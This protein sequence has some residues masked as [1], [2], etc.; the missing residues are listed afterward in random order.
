MKSVFGIVLGLLA[1]GAVGCGSSAAGSCD[2]SV[3]GSHVCSEYGAGYT[4]DNV[5]AACASPG[6][7][8]AGSCSSTD[9]V[10]RCTITAGSTTYTQHYYPPMTSA[11]AT[12]A[13]TAASGTF[14]AN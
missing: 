5:R 14:T 9:R 8:S 7:Y 2:I 3:S 12:A 11:I 13:C 10:G 4:A 6:V 1:V